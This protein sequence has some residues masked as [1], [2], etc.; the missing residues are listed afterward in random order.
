V[1]F[2]RALNKPIVLYDS[3]ATLS[4]AEGAQEMSRNLMIDYA[5]SKTVSKLK[6]IPQVVE[7]LL[8]QS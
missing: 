6:S 2:G 3:K 8:S 5:A 1:G 4:F 7:S